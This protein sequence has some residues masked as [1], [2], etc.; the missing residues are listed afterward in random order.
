LGPRSQAS[1]FL[2]ARHNIEC[3][4]FPPSLARENPGPGVSER[5]LAY[6]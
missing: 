4:V 2:H 1:K 6:H 5:C 3:K